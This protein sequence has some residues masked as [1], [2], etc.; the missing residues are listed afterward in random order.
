M[1][2]ASSADREIQLKWSGMVESRLRQLIGRLESVDTVDL[3]IFLSRLLWL[4]HPYIK[5]FEAAMECRNQA[6]ADLVAN[7]GKLPTVDSDR[8]ELPDGD[9][10]IVVQMTS[11]YVGLKT[12]S[13][14]LDI[15]WPV[16][17]FTAMVQSWDSYD[18]SAMH[19]SVTYLKRYSL[20]YWSV[21]YVRHY[22]KDLPEELFEG[23]PRPVKKKSRK[24]KSNKQ[25]ASATDTS[26]DPQSKKVKSS[27]L[28]DEIDTG[29]AEATKISDEGEAFMEPLQEGGPDQQ[30][31]EY[32]APK[33]PSAEMFAFLSLSFCRSRT[34][35]SPT[36]PGPQIA[37]KSSYSG[38][39]GAVVKKKSS[40]AKIVQ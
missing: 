37:V 20:W 21:F 25:E 22:S 1:V 27:L 36:P 5:G 10:P 29:V 12:N 38:L 30:K 28:E 4:A 6:E 39:G 2:I 26:A 15:G 19:I 13:K 3:G 16:N 40:R 32:A 8:P 31:V 33:D 24:R 11:F 17:D 7:G 23:K 34:T 35:S 9:S 14:K 18:A